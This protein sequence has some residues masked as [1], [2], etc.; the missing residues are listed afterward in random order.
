MLDIDIEI[1]EKEFY[2]KR[3]YFSYS[4]INKL[5][6]S[7]IVWYRH[8]VLNQRDDKT[9]LYL[10]NGKVIHCLLLDNGSFASSFV[11]SP[12][13]LPTGNN[14]IVIDKVFNMAVATDRISEELKFFDV[15][16]LEILVQI[17]LH[18]S[19]KTDEQRL[20]KI[21]NDSNI[22][23]FNY[24]K[25]KDGRDV[26]DQ[27][28]LTSCVESVD[29]LK[30]NDKIC[31][32]LHCNEDKSENIE[33]LNEI[34]I[35]I[36]LGTV[37]PFGLKGILDNLV[38]NK[39]EKIIYI[40]DLKTT[41]KTI[42]DFRDTIEYYNY[43]LQ[44]AIYLMMVRDKY[45]DILADHEWKIKF[46]FIVI[47]K[48]NQIYPFEVSDLTMSAWSDK[49]HDTLRIA[50]YHYVNREFALPYEFACNKVIL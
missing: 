44:A 24:L 4:G 7:P 36:D 46:C 42:S 35:E 1:L 25:T 45:K 28:T 47:D 13:N 27:E 49:L 48:Y 33:I 39:K 20:D 18:Q 50:E 12:D 21:I 26:I 40:N 14:K 23:Y 32:L 2:S 29:I 9:D 8:Y 38:I 5:L 22:N 31:S 43:W 37:Y 30:K 41:G 6:F 10:I 3:F 16:I 11:V 19:L 17:N 15:T 34:K